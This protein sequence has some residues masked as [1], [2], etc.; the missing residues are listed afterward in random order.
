M[1]HNSTQLTNDLYNLKLEETYRLITFDIRDLYVNLPIQEILQI[2]EFLLRSKKLDKLVIQQTLQLLN[3][4][5]IQNY[6]QFEDSFYQPEK[7][8]TMGSPISSIVAEIFLQYHEEY[9]VKHHLES[10]RILF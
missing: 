2:T 3:I 5:L 10:K 1:S 6:C 4:I 7:G 8:V 9:T